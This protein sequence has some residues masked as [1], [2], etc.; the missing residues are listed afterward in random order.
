MSN[1]VAIIEFETDAGVLAAKSD[2]VKDGDDNDAADQ[3]G[4]GFEAVHGL[5]L[6]VGPVLMSPHD[7]ARRRENPCGGT[8]V[9]SAYSGGSSV[10][11]AR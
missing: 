3:R 11:A 5:V 1:A 9:E 10:A 2:A 7:R 8:A 4:E 6:F